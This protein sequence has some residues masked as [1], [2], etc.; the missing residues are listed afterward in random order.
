[1][2]TRAATKLTPLLV[3]CLLSSAV[4][5]AGALGA[6]GTDDVGAAGVL[7]GAV[8]VDGAAD[9]GSADLV[10]GAPSREDPTVKNPHRVLWPLE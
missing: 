1:M 3:K 9:L 5:V 2:L 10:E 4:L 8:V 7:G 6:A